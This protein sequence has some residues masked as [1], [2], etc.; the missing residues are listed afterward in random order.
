MALS[1]SDGLPKETKLAR[2]VHE[3]VK[4]ESGDPRARGSLGD[5]LEELVRVLELPDDHRHVNGP[6]EDPPAALGDALG[7]DA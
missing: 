6:M 4:H 5:W 7:S 3:I 2:C 1:G